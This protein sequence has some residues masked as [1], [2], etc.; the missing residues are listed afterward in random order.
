MKYKMFRIAFLI[1]ISRQ[2]RYRL[3][4]IL[5][6]ALQNFEKKRGEGSCDALL[7]LTEFGSMI[8][9]NKT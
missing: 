3:D 1:I 9:K 2:F 8:I 5:T 6:Y 4:G 7:F